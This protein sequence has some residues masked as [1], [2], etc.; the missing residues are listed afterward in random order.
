MSFE[1]RKDL[2]QLVGVRWGPLGFA[3]RCLFLDILNEVELWAEIGGVVG[4]SYQWSTGDVAE[5]FG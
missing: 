1:T 2:L 5:A 4:A 3:C